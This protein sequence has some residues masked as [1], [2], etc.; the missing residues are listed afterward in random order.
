ME[1]VATCANDS[2]ICMRI[3]LEVFE[4]LMRLVT[5]N[6]TTPIKTITEINFAAIGQSI[7]RKNLDIM[8]SFHRTVKFRFVAYPFL[9]F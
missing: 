4:L 6:G 7:T 9:D 1:L 8:S 5:A 2:P 3:V